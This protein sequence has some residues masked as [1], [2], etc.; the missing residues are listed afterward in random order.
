MEK[1]KKWLE[2][3]PRRRPF[4]LMT[5]NKLIDACIN[6]FGG[7]KSLN[8]GS[9]NEELIHC[10]C[11][12]QSN[13]SAN[14]APQTYRADNNPPEASSVLTDMVLPQIVKSSF[15]PK[16]SAK[17]KTSIVRWAMTLNYRMINS[18]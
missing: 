15:L 12:Y 13:P 1:I 4:A 2:V 18:F 10:L 16:L 14:S 8:E 17:G 6:K 3:E 7:K 9:S 5:K 11:T